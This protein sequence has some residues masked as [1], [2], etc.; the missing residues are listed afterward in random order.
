MG[1]TATNYQ[2]Q[3]GD[4]VFVSSRSCLDELMFW[5][6]SRP[7]ERCTGCNKACQ[8]PEMLMAK[9]M[10]MVQDAMIKPG[11]MGWMPSDSDPIQGTGFSERVHVDPR[12]HMSQPRPGASTTIEADVDGELEFAPLTE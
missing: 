6:A 8:Y 7:C 12:S 11:S 10:P 5:K 1:N 9:P 4:R 3:P 2:L